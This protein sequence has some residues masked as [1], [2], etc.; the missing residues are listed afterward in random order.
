VVDANVLRHEVGRIC[1]AQRR[2]ILVTGANTRAF[3][4]FCA[5]HVI[6][7]VERHARRWA[8]ELQVDY[9]LFIKTWNSTYVPLLR[10][11]DTSSLETML[12]PDE[13]ARVEQLRT[14]R[15]PDDV[16]SVTLALAM[17]ALFLTEDKAPYEAVHGR[18]TNRTEI[19]AW[20]S[21]LRDGGNAEELNKI[22]SVTLFF[23]LAS[24][25]AVFSAGRWLH[26]RSAL[27]MLGVCIA[28]AVGAVLVPQ[29]LYRRGWMTI[30]DVVSTV[31]DG[32]IMPQLQASQRVRSALSP[33]PNWSELVQGSTPDDA[34]ARACLYQLARSRNS[35]SRPG[36]LARELPSLGISTA[37]ARVGKMLHQRQ[38]FYEPYRGKW[39]I[40]QPIGA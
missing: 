21:L 9:S 4:L 17:G 14:R 16:P 32:L 15:D 39:Q 38:C 7:E 2:T 26:A 29:S 34:L 6:E 40:G 37:A 20:L 8:T 13:R 30:K 36:Q 10:R 25:A 31:G 24:I 5:D 35:P 19:R 33:F 28:S 1:R 23:P 12:L 18:K 3:R 27:A 22:N 11:V